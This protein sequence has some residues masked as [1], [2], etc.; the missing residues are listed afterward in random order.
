[1]FNDNFDTCMFACFL[2]QEEPKRVHQALKDPSWI[3]AMHEKLLQFKMQIVLILVDLHHEK[4]AI[5]ARIKAIRLLLAYA[6]SMGFMVYQMDVKSAFLYETIEEE[7]YVCQ[8]S[9]FEDPDHP[10]KIYV[11]DIIFGA[12]NKDLC[13][14][15]EK[16]MK[17]KFQMSSMG[18]LTFFLGLQVK[19]KRD[20]IFISRDKYVAEILKKF[21]LTEGKS[22]STPID[23][24]KPL[25]KDPDG[26]DVDVRTYRS[27]IG[28]LMYLTSL[29][30]DIMFAEIYNWGCQFLGCRLISWQCKKQTVVA[31]SSTE[32]Q[33]LVQ[34]NAAQRHILL[35][36][37][38]L[39]FGLTLQVV[40]NGVNTP[41]CD[42]DRLELMEK[43][44]KI[45]IG[46]NV[47]DLQ[48]SVVNDVTR[49]QALVDKKKVVVTE[50]T[51]REALRLDDEEGV[52]CLPNEEIFV[53][54]ARIGYEK[55]STKLM[56]YKAFF[57]SQWNLVRIVDSPT[58]FYMY[59]RFLQ[60]MIRKQVGD[61]STH[62]TKYTS[63]ALTQ[64]VF[65]NMRRVGK[66]F[67]RVE[68]PLFEG[69]LV[70]QHVI[71]EEDADETVNA[72][73]AAK[74]DVSAAHKEVPT[75]AEK[76]SIPSPTLPTPP[77]Q[78]P[79]DIPST[80]H[81]QPTPPQ[82]PQNLLQEV[83][84]TCTAL[85]RRV[86]H[87][88]FNKVAQ[89]LEITKLKR[90]V[91]K[92]KR[93]NKVR[94]LKLRRLQR[95]GTLQRVETSDETVIDD[96]S[97]QG[98]MIDE[99]DDD[100]NV[101]LE[102]VKEA[103]D[104]AKEVA[105]DAKD[106]I[107]PAKVQEVV[108]V[109]TTAKLITKV[110]T[111]A[112]ETVTAASAIITTAEAQ[113][114]TATLTATPARVTTAPSRR[115][116][117]VV[118]TD[119]QEKSTT[120]TIIPAKT[121]FKDKELHA[122]LSK[123]IDWDEFIDHVK[124]KA[125]EDPT[126]NDITRLHALV[127]EKKVV[128]T[129]A[130]IREVLW[131]DDAEGVD[132]LPEEIF[133]ELARMGY[134]KPSTKLTFYKAFFS[135]QWKFLIH[136]ILLSIS[137]KQTSWNEF[138][139][140]MAS[141]IISLSTGQEIEEEGDADEHVEDVTVGDDA[142]GDYTAA[143][144]EVQPP[145]PQPQPQQQVAD[146]PMSLLQEALDACAAL[147]RRGR[148]IDE[149]DK[150]DA[151][152]LMD[153]KEEDKKVEE[154]KVD[155]SAQEVVDVVTTAKL[156]TEVVTAASV[157]ISDAKPQ[158]YVA[159]IIAAP[160][161]VAA[162]PKPK[163]LKKK[164]HIEMDEEYARKL[165]A[166]INKDIDWDVAIDHVKLKF[167]EDQAIQ[168]Y[169]VM[170]R[171]PQTEEQIEEEDNRALQT[172]NETPTQ[173]AAKRS[174]LNKEVEDLKRHLEILPDENDD[175]YTEATPLARKLE[176]CLRNQMHRL[177]SGGIKELYMVK[178]MLRAGSYWNHVM[179]TK[180]MLIEDTNDV[181]QKK[182]RIFISQ[183]K[184]VAEIL[185]KF[186]LIDEKSTSTPIDTEKPLLKD[187]DGE[188][189]DV[190]TY[191]LMIGSLMYLTSSRLDIMLAVCAC[192]RFQVTPKASH[193]HA[194]KRIFRY[195]KG[196][197][198]LGL[199]YPKDSPFELV[200]YSDSDYAGAS[201]DRKST[202]GGCQFLGCRLIS[203]QC[204]KKTVVATS[205]TEAE[206]AAAAS[207][208]AQVN[209]VTRLQSLVNKKKVV[210]TEAI[211]REA[212]HLDDTE[213][214]D[215]LSNE[216]IFA[217]LTRMGYEKPSTK[218]T[219]YKAFFSSQRKF[220]IHTILQCMSAKRTSWN[221]FSSS[222]ASAVI[223]LSSGRKFNFSKYIFDSWVRNV[224]STTKFYRYPCFLQ[225][226]IRKQVGNLST[227]TIKY[228]S[229]ALTQKVFANIRRVGKGFSG[230]ETPLFEGMLVEQEEPSIPSP[231][232]P[233]LPPQPPQD[234]PSTSQA[235]Q[236]PPQS[237]Q[238][239]GK[240]IMVREPKPLKKK[241][242]IEHD[243]AYARELEAEL[244]KNIDWDEVIEQVQR[245]EKE[246]NAVM[247][248]M[249]GF[250]ID[251]FKGMTYDDIRPIF[252]KNFNSNMSFLEKTRE[253]ME[254][255]DNKALKR[256]SESQ[257]DKVAKKQ[258]LDEEVEE[259]RKHLLIFQMMMM[260]FT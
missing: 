186:G 131:L 231:T 83:M 135:S 236:T 9:G 2:S 37:I 179:K 256:I 52:D 68:T 194:I 73:D 168:R 29:R 257:E 108:E 57:S 249:A 54:L 96:V 158:V 225:L 116:K 49:L 17:D 170:K 130:A 183:D 112:S 109:F 66:G 13:K 110:V 77:P 202:T 239:K 25:L 222:M 35:N 245:K 192:A 128:V 198:H 51:I 259:L 3:E 238:D 248:N 100:A 113:V 169:Q 141:A 64:K 212:L 36:C 142:Q 34:C 138:S 178:Q 30:P 23:T 235:H 148:M 1:M 221:E 10:D 171:K 24:E 234:I 93:R 60:L 182:D 205:S 174:K 220:L 91:K 193:L 59:P 63:L 184:Y 90:R 62:T 99:V 107:E 134:E 15:F 111:A 70:E 237:P 16:L 247:R 26:K 58:K 216:E 165:H 258:K 5:V 12:T 86:E 195:L 244:N 81:V 203:W 124:L 92:L 188:D 44:E 209:D 200:S 136:T 140:A 122:E 20:G 204:K 38:I 33:L 260:L 215:C 8:P 84:D 137:A 139:S 89:A 11:D 154:A 240:G 151:V 191:R 210:L 164:Q 161:K 102:D 118:I 39:G 106:E 126:V 197:P 120:S 241:T 159:T 167:K 251:Y 219:F 181:N 201:L 71:E 255:E 48:V 162:A 115:R 157:I 74:G 156:I 31:T 147:T 206:Y 173:K 190:H 250:K 172:I 67:S 224:D 199:W 254:E 87:L 103:A 132:C 143:H 226:I 14:S 185:R 196:K 88:E 19:K 160:I 75:V 123:N 97:N 56:F 65:A 146:F 155:E 98:R 53:E 18:E 117:G 208:C 61:L 40:L 233:T 166:E 127:D 176:Q 72:S 6:S 230:V 105:E 252:E 228:T 163:P 213:G 211:I 7:V 79:Q 95:V 32:F 45:R 27:M 76:P 149:I 21:R 175:V 101:V 22:A 119:L 214:L 41:R 80:F 69:M 42:E 50:S 217:E 153:E 94:V 144:G 242:Q 121:K 246:D 218:L 253:Q 78:P 152:V 55:P 145:S 104:E 229:P 243:E 47:V 85:T 177:K 223:C 4:R 125:N 187:P 180:L 227:H 28:S 114:P 46:V 207:C 133:T 129:E 232:P 43:I 150:D 189:V 82:S